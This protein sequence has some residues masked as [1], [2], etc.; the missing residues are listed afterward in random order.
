M[1]LT[2]IE[3]KENPFFKRK[4]LKIRLKQTGPTPSKAEIVKELAAKYGVD[5]S[6]V[7][8]DYIFSKRGLRESFVNCKILQEKPKIEKP[9]PAEEQKPA[10]EGA[11]K[12]E[13]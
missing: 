4:D 6:Q 9:K 5:E 2:I 11:E 3:E 8:I 12:N 13:A 1:E 7:Q 10:A